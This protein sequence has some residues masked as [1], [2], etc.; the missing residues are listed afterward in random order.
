MKHV[1]KYGQLDLTTYTCNYHSTSQAVLVKS[2]HYTPSC[3]FGCCPPSRWLPKTPDTELMN[4]RLE[5][6]RAHSTTRRSTGHQSLQTGSSRNHWA[7]HGATCKLNL[8]L[9]VSLNLSMGG[10]FNEPIMTCQP[11]NFVGYSLSLMCQANISTVA[12]TT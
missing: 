4:C 11:I 7:L 3:F 6:W 10:L 1:C 12:G 8:V 9:V 2:H 5:I